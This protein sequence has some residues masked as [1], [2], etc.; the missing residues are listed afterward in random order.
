MLYGSYHDLQN[1]AYRNRMSHPLR[2]WQPL[3]R[4]SPAESVLGLGQSGDQCAVIVWNTVYMAA[5]IEQLK[6]EKALRCR[7][8]TSPMSGPPGMP[9]STCMANTTL[10]LRRLKDGRA[11]SSYPKI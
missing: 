1:H 3:L 8:A 4:S 9:I 6:Q 10:T 5:V 7:T 11:Y 2:R